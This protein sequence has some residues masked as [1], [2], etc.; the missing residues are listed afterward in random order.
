MKILILTALAYYNRSYSLSGVIKS[1]AQ[2]LKEQGHEVD[3]G[4]AKGMTGKE[5]FNGFTLHEVIDHDNTLNNIRQIIGNY[6]MVFTHDFVWVEYMSWLNKILDTLEVEFPMVQFIHH[7]HSAPGDPSREVCQSWRAGRNRHNVLYAYPNDSDRIRFADYIGIPHD[8]AITIRLS[9]NFIDKMGGD[10][11]LYN[12]L[13]LFDVDYVGFYPAHLMPGKNAPAILKIVQGMKRQG[14]KVKYIFTANGMDNNGTLDRLNE[15]RKMTKE[16]D[17]EDSIIWM[18]DYPEWKGNVDYE[19]VQKIWKVT[20]LFIMA[21]I[22]ETTSL[23]LLEAMAHRCLIVANREQDFPMYKELLG[24]GAI[25]HQFGNHWGGIAVQNDQMASEV[26]TLVRQWFEKHNALYCF[27]RVKKTYNRN[28]IYQAYYK[29]LFERP[30]EAVIMPK[31]SVVIPIMNTC[32]ELIEYTKRCIECVRD[33]S[34]AEVILVNNHKDDT[35]EYDTDKMITFTENEGVA[36][37]WN[38]GLY[39]A[40]GEYVMFLNSD[41]FLPKDWAIKMLA[42]TDKGMVFPWVKDRQVPDGVTEIPNEKFM[43][44]YV[45]GCCFM[46]RHSTFNKIGGFWEGFGLG[47]YEDKNY[48]DRCVANGVRAYR[49]NIEVEHKMNATSG[50][51]ANLND[52]IGNSEKKY[53]ELIKFGY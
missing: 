27:D 16:L 28:H 21:S 7:A 33:Y 49:A 10:E 52:I 43:F 34:N 14:M 6:D 32:E 24:N 1:Q 31:I 12:K 8:K 38:H 23:M 9:N 2:L 44:D 4:V 19:T 15:Y 13:G 11:A 25:Y 45:H 37:A 26:A 41:V 42:Q 50:K 20:N 30:Q 29:P 17:I 39:E 36:R 40:T 48:W 3:L 35:T 47:Y 53:R 18:P 5:H 46:S 22:S 51:L